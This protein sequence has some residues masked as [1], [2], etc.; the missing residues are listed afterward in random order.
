VVSYGDMLYRSLDAVTSLRE[1]GFDIGLVNKVTLNII[2]EESLAEMGSKDFVLV[3]ESWSQKTGLG[4]KLGTWLL[5]RGHTMR[6]GY[7][8]TRREGCGGTWEQIPH[9]GLAPEHIVNRLRALI[10]VLRDF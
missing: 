8:G 2:D 10:G 3:V 4:S 6:Y 7:M 1:K 5:E 9:Q